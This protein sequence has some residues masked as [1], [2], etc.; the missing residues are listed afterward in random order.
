M[1]SSP[2]TWFVLLFAAFA[3]L[4]TPTRVSAQ[5]AQMRDSISST[6]D[7]WV[8]Q[9]VTLVVELLAPGIFAGSPSFDLPDPQG[10]LIVP[11]AGSPTLSS[12][13]ID[14]VSYTVQRHELSVF[15]HRAGELTIPAFTVRI[16]FKRQPLD[17]DAASAALTTAPIKLS[18]QSP[19]GMDGRDGII[20]ARDLTATETWKP[21][22]ASCKAGDAF[23]RTITWSAPDIPAMA[24]PPFPAG[25]VEGLGIYPRAPEVHDQTDR[26]Q[27]RGERQ[28]T[29]TYVCERPGR[30]VIPAVRFTWFDMESKTAKVIEFPARAFAVTGPTSAPASNVA[31]GSSGFGSRH[32]VALVIALSA[33]GILIAAALLLIRWWPQWSAP[34]RSVALA[35]LNP[36]ADLTGR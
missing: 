16:H 11:P 30:F 9:R 17:K 10:I 34:F 13:T 27:L 28:D 21:E 3:L 5:E 24:F 23:I 12:E 26:G 19:P 6:G 20:S 18:V 33:G 8:G 29:I 7:I 1:K 4:N 36:S 22:P 35:P 31:A 14:G 32:K 15:P 25:R 2:L